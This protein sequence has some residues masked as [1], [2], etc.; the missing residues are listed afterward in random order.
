MN[1]MTD[2]V[3]V[4]I[5]SALY[6]C[7]EKNTERRTICTQPFDD[8]RN[9]TAGGPRNDGLTQAALAAE[10]GFLGPHTSH[11]PRCKSPS[12]FESEPWPWH[13]WGNG[14]KARS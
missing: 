4:Y 1:M 12:A 2:M 8:R 14:H 3:Y 7:G 10:P 11:W 6:T 5:G 13:P 9:S